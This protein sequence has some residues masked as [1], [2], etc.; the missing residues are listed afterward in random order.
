[1]TNKMD[2]KKKIFGLEKCFFHRI[3]KFF[4]RHIYQNGI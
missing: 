2:E 3:N 1:M 4:H